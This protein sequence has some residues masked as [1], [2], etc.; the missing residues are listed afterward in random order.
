MY[1]C[2]PEQVRRPSEE[3]LALLRMLPGELRKFRDT[4][5]ERGGHVVELDGSVLPPEEEERENRGLEDVEMGR[6][7]PERMEVRQDERMSMAAPNA[8]SG[9]A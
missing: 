6:D 1:R 2:A 9:V 8:S 5:R 7:M 4:V 3:Q